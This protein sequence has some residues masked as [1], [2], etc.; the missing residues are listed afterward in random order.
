MLARRSLF[1]VVVLTCLTYADIIEDVRMAAARN[2]FAQAD[3]ALLAY[4]TQKGITPEY[5]EA[6]SWLARG[7]ISAN[8]LDQA[9]SYARMT[10]KLAREQLH[11]RAFDAE[12]HLPMAMGA[13]I[14][15]QA[16]SLAARGH[17]AQAVALLKRNLLFYGKTSIQARLQKNLNL[18]VL[19][20]QP[21]PVLDHAKTLGVSAPS[22]AQLKGSPVLLFF[23]AH[24]CGDCK[25][26]GPII[27]SLSSEFAVKGLKVIAPSQLYGYAAAGQDASPAAELAY[28][29]K[30]W[31]HYYSALQSVAVPISKQNFDRYGVSTTPTLVVLDRAGRV[32][33]YHPGA[34]QYQELRTAIEKVL[35][36]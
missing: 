27:A 33:L 2:N 25:A 19:T 1:V 8:Q 9:D 34:M 29:S 7:A 15:V 30:V 4:R 36:N 24:W 21:A 17:S 6:L 12:P 13:A 14:E 3:A 28:I 18:L 35:S 31:Q 11:T 32:S 23:W 16:Q 20:G 5:I 26:E 22:L 10:I